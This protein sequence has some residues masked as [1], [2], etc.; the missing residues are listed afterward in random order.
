[1]ELEVFFQ[2]YMDIEYT[3]Y[4]TP[5]VSVLMPIRNEAQYIEAS[6]G[7]VL[8][9]DY[10]SDKIEILIMDG[11]STDETRSIINR[12][13]EQP[14]IKEKFAAIYLLD[15]PSH[16][17][18][19]AFNIGLAKARGDVIVRV[20]GHCEIASNYISKCIEILNRTRADCVG[21]EITTIGRTRTAK[22]ISLAQST[23][24]GVGD[25]IAR[26]RKNWSGYVDTVCFGAYRKEVFAKIGLFDEELIRNQDDEFNARL[27]Q[28]G[29][30]I[31]LDSEVKSTYFSRATLKGLWHQYLYY[32][33]YKIR[34][35]QKR[36]M[37]PSMRQLMPPLFIIGIIAVT[38]LSFCAGTP[39]WIMSYAGV[40][41]GM[42]LLASIWIA[43][44]VRRFYFMLP[45]IF[46]TLHVS[47]GIGYLWGLW[48]WRRFW[49]RIN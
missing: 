6:L 22:S 15:N 34:F 35:L 21:G 47:Y 13:I 33:F 37:L 32:G 40:Y 39:I 29:G 1:M 27:V 14:D 42:S 5:F 9:Q 28:A 23:F 8:R 2:E 11:L 7:A 3:E 10:P 25:V 17:V 4:K 45:L 24:F 30:K 31:W 46:I 48:E 19:S 44:R 41:L 26:R 38:G 12:I 20:D 36:K 49:N 18:S 43:S 16:I